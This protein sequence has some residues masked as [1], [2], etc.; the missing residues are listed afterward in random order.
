MRIKILGREFDTYQ[1]AVRFLKLTIKIEA[2]EKIRQQ[3]EHKLKYLKV[4][5]ELAKEKALD[6]KHRRKE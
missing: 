5:L 3:L 2:N 4:E 6:K 1:E